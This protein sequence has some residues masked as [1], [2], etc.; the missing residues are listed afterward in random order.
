[1]FAYYLN[2]ALRSLK[3]NRMLT[4]LMILTIA[5][6]VGATM[7]AL[8]VYKVLSGNPI[9]AKSDVLYRVQVDSYPKGTQQANDEPPTDLTRTDAEN[10]LAEAKGV[11]QTITNGG[12]ALVELDGGNQGPAR[13]AARHA[14]ADFFGMFNVPIVQG[15]AWSRSDDQ[16][17]SR[18]ALINYQLAEKLFGTA[19]PVGRPIRIGSDTFQIIGVVGQWKVNP[20]FYDLS[21]G[22]FGG[23][24]RVFVPY[25]TAR[26]L[27]MGVAGNMDCNERIPDGKQ[28]T[29]LGMRCHWLNYWVELPDARSRD[30]YR[31]YLEQYSARQLENGWFGRPPNV[32][33]RNVMD[34]LDFRKVVPPDVKL[35]LWLAL[36]FLLVCMTNVVGLL[37][38]KFLRRS[39]EVGVRRALG[40]TRSEIFRQFLTE[41]AIIGAVGGLG[42]LLLAWLGLTA[43]RKQPVDYASLAHMDMTMLFATVM[44]AIIVTLF[45]GALPAWRAMRI[46]PAI[47]LKSQ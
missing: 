25:S 8:T 2:L 15:R 13:V 31:S 24:E 28:S 46:T 43:V 42:G 18:V 26:E 1:M 3:R 36:G 30:D 35:Q 21:S 40:A 5:I 17:H 19:S 39:G 16:N 22:K 7:T 10:L 14:T 9:P 11:R 41:A 12:D 4:L 27:D 23:Q 44:L 20:R 6:G 37:L 33:L 34:W 45:A 29:D 32:R 38:A 47:Q